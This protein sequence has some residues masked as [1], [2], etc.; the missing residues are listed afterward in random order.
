MEVGGWALAQVKEKV[1]GKVCMH[2]RH[3]TFWGEKIIH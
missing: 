1:P 2:D 3:R